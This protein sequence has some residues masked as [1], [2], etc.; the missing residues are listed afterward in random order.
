MILSLCDYLNYGEQ[1]ML[2]LLVF[3]FRFTLFLCGY[4]LSHLYF[5]LITIL[6][7]FLTEKSIFK[8]FLYHIY[9]NIIYTGGLGLWRLTPLSTTFQLYHGDQFFFGGG[10]RSTLRKPPTCHKSLTNF[11]T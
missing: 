7:I 9:I 6:D 3:L 4:L 2:T 1:D 5:F 10:N 8:S 11:I